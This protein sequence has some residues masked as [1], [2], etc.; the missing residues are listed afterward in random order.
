MKKL[1]TT[2]LAALRH[3]LTRED[4]KIACDRCTGKALRDRGFAVELVRHVPGRTVTREHFYITPEGQERAKKPADRITK[5]T[6]GAPLD[7]S[8]LQ[9]LTLDRSH[10]QA[11]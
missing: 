11:H 8:L 9:P 5:P 3:A 7:P 6:S 4:G 2:Q 1:N 10:A